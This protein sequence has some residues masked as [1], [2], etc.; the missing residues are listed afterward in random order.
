M[1]S[2]ELRSGKPEMFDDYYRLYVQ[3]TLETYGKNNTT[4]DQLRGE[5]EESGHDPESHFLGV[6]HEDVMIGY[7]NLTAPRVPPVRPYLFGYVDPTHRGN[8]LGTKIAQWGKKQAQIFVPLCPPEARI[9]LQGVTQH[10]EGVELLIQAGFVRS[11]ESLQLHLDFTPPLPHPPSLPEGYRIRTLAD[12][13]EVFEIAQVH[14]RSF[15]DHRGHLPQ[16]PERIAAQ[17]QKEFDHAPN[18]D[19]HLVGVLDVDDRAAAFFI[20]L[21]ESEDD[22]DLGWIDGL[23][24]DP[25][26]RRRGIAGLLLDHCFAELAAKGKKGVDLVVDGSSLTGADRLYYRKG[27]TLRQTYTIMD[28][29]VREGI[30]IT[31]QG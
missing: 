27:M 4:P 10:K 8:G 17:Y 29:L 16:P 30:E 25:L 19:P 26:F 11:R 2:Y 9:V 28:Y 20:A 14:G 22:P 5:W 13:L 1:K 3:E 21:P 31:P 18:F 24:V 12:G 7:G 23:G 15:R 6:F